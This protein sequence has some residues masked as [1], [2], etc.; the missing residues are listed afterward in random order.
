MIRPVSVCLVAP[1]PPPYGGISQ[2]TR[3]V[4]ER[5]ARSASVRLRLLN[6]APRWRAVEDAAVWKRAIWGALPLVATA[7]RLLVCCVRREADVVHVATSGGLSI[8]RDL[9]LLTIA[10]CLRV[11][12]S[13]H[14]H[15]GRLPEVA[16][17]GTTEWRLTT[18]A[19]R[20]ASTV[21]SIDKATDDLIRAALP[22]VES[23]RI[24]NCVD[25][26]RVPSWDSSA[27]CQ[28]TA[29]FIGWV[30]PTKGCGELIEAW[31]RLH[32]RGWR[33]VIVGP[34]GSGYKEE[35][36]R[37]HDIHNVEFAGEMPHD[38]AMVLLA[39]ADMLVLPS[40][41]E[42]CPNVVLE[43]MA[44]GRAVVA[45]EVGALPEMLAGGCG[46]L[47][48]PRDVVALTAAME[49]VMDS[50]SLR[51]ALGEQA[52]Q[53]ATSVYSVESVF[54]KYVAL[55]RR[56]PL[57]QHRA[58]D[59]AA[60]RGPLSVCLAAPL[61]PPYGGISHWAQMIRAHS[62]T[63]PSVVVSVV[64]TSPRWHMAEHRGPWR[65]AL[66]GVLRLPSQVL[67]FRR[68]LRRRAHVAHVTTS[69]G[70]SVVRDYLMLRVARRS[71][72]PAIYHIRIGR[73]PSLIRKCSLEWWALAATM[74]NAHTVVVI[75]E[76]TESVV[77]ERLPETRVV[78]LPNCI[79]LAALPGPRAS[80]GGSRTALFI[81]WILPSKGLE[82][83][84]AAWS[85]LDSGGWRLVIVGPDGTGYEDRLRERY[86]P[87]SVE[88]RGE[89]EHREAMLLLAEA[90]LLI[91][92]SHTEGFPNVI[93]EAM[94]LGLAIVATTVGAI[95][96]M[97]ADDCG[98]LVPPCDAEALAK[99]MGEVMG[100]AALR[101]RLGSRASRR[102]RQ[103]YS[104]DEVFE[105]YV[106]L[107][108]QASVAPPGGVP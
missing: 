94:A 68:A 35:L 67:G 102:A 58:R 22:D 65:R 18:M 60:T 64:N 3:L 42:G 17:R 106:A 53:R 21:V 8:V 43:A 55:W 77:R 33:L 26:R 49:T 2:W 107:W 48:P 36:L 31:S 81:G 76:L 104:L 15:F 66:G 4:L 83:L 32:R 40:Y 50:A 47:V 101:A 91:L 72:V 9:V 73:I 1:L 57:R 79:D 20:F 41:T 74:R 89:M 105:R 27:A 19:M 28:R 29:L 13:Y 82:E 61:P 103:R 100:S 59:A 11:P 14:L 7:A 54:D 44:L 86:R 99:A 63:H 56:L 75:D 69:G 5:G 52:R 90:D 87:A 38:Q 25:L 24:P 95:P 92:P 71:R 51:S 98:I 62:A 34:G 80:A 16:R 93:L 6:T 39:A 88:F 10:R 70:L 97:L 12:A 84:V 23:V 45:T 85:A 78:R 108:R 30:V 96:E 37:S 46:L